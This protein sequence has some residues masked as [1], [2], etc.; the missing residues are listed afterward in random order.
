MT[1][2]IRQAYV[3]NTLT[4]DNWSHAFEKVSPHTKKEQLIVTRPS[5]EYTKIQSKIT[6]V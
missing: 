3:S 4:S 5:K 1:T 2:R 6:R